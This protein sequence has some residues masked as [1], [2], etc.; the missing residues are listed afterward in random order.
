MFSPSAAPRWKI[1]TSRR[2]GCAASAIIAARARNPGPAAMPTTL[3]A[4]PFKKT[5]R[6]IPIAY[7]LTPLK[8][9]RAQNQ[10]SHRALG[11]RLRR[12]VQLAPRHQ[13]IAQLFG[14]RFVLLR[15]DCSGQQRLLQRA[16]L[17]F[18][19]DAV[20]RQLRGVNLHY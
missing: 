11:Y 2:C 12:I 5:R 16:L 18:G 17:L 14:N 15:R 1:T 20:A 4:P 13:G 6:V 3:M 19:L 10:S 8:F 7:L 9:R